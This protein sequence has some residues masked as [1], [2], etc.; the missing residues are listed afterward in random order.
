MIFTR[1]TFGMLYK[2]KLISSR[3]AKAKNCMGLFNTK[4]SKMNK[5][6]RLEKHLLICRQKSLDT[7]FK[8]TNH[9]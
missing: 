3:V 4:T 1:S 2:H 5:K 7:V 8:L 9:V 6:F